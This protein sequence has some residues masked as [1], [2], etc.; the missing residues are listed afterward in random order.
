MS[1]VYGLITLCV[2]KVIDS[3]INC[4]WVLLGTIL[5]L[6]RK[7]VN[8]DKFHYTEIL[9]FKKFALNITYTFIYYFKNTCFSPVIINLGKLVTNKL[10]FLLLNLAWGITRIKLKVITLE[11]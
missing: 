9:L 11:L 10:E 1:A 4:L 5:A 7:T 8:F 3:W 2:Y 6:D